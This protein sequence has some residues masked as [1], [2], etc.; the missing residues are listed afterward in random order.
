MEISNSMVEAVSIRRMT[1]EK[2][3]K[4]VRQSCDLDIMGGREDG[5]HLKKKLH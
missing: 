3:L 1:K 5:V 2:Q 4:I